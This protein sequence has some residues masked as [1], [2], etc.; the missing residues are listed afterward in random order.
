M[1][2]SQLWAT[3]RASQIPTK[4]TSGAHETHSKPTEQQAAC[5]TLGY[6]R[7]RWDEE[8]SELAASRMMAAERDA[9]EQ[10]RAQ[11]AADAAAAGLLS[12]P[13][14]CRRVRPASRHRY[15]DLVHPSRR[16]ARRRLPQPV[17]HAKKQGTHASACIR[18][19]ASTRTHACTRT[20][21]RTCART[22]IR[23]LQGA[24]G[25]ARALFTYDAP[26][27]SFGDATNAPTSGAV[28]ISINGAKFGQMDLTPTARIGKSR[29]A[30]SSW[31]SGKLC[32]K[33][34]W[35]QVLADRHL[36]N[37]RPTL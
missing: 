17:T 15:P 13:N 2:P 5:R 12:R 28:R 29:C 4:P 11:E 25:T 33:H 20:H 21:A 32:D 34:S 23:S 30:T 9:E 26:V 16:R 6:D 31:I 8:R 1:A 24:V 14:F 37:N 36:F 19:H 10:L 27:V 35:Y 22:H 3:I 18:T 7:S